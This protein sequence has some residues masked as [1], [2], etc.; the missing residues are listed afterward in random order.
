MADKSAQ[1]VLARLADK[2]AELIVLARHVWP[3]NWRRDYEPL[4]EKS[5]FLSLLGLIHNSGN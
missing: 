1:T 3:I 4:T 2:S 5:L